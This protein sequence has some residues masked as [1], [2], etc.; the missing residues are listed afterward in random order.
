MDVRLAL[1]YHL[2][3]QQT[4]HAPLKPG[5]W[6]L[7][8]TGKL[9]IVAHESAFVQSRNQLLTRFALDSLI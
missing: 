3:M 6:S 4:M 2:L 8:Q 7:L 1:Q 5:R 9:I